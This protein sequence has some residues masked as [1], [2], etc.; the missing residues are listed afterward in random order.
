VAGYEADAV[1]V[2]V[3]ISVVIAAAGVVVLVLGYAV[4][5]LPLE[6]AT[7][8]HWRAPLLLVPGG[9]E[10][11]RDSGRRALAN[12]CCPGA[13]RRS[14]CGRFAEQP[15]AHVIFIGV[16]WDGVA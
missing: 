10:V 13:K 16:R 4:V 5:Q 11:C 9:F 1:E 6:D 14:E 7:H 2:P 15:V 12:R 3:A 8:A